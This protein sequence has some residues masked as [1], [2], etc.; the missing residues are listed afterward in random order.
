MG[1]APTAAREPASAAS[2]G[3]L[4]R[5]PGRARCHANGG[6]I[7]RLAG[8]RLSPRP[9]HCR[10]RLA[11]GNGVL[12]RSSPGIEAS[13][14]AEADRPGRCPCT[15]EELHDPRRVR[16]RRS[17]FLAVTVLPSR[18]VGATSRSR[19]RPRNALLHRGRRMHGGVGQI[20][21]AFFP[22]SA[23]AALAD[24]GGEDRTA[25]R[26]RRHRRRRRPVCPT[27]R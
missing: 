16:A 2:T 12:A 21:S 27:R 23:V 7:P 1:I 11:E 6:H 14:G 13:F 25:H 15:A 24:P 8:F 19:C 17:L 5:V 3:G 4:P 9:L 26:D 20:W 18:S 10:G 22:R